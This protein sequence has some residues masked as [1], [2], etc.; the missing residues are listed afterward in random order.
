MVWLAIVL[1]V[2]AVSLTWFVLHGGAE[3]AVD[4]PI[5][6]WV[7]AHRVDALTPVVKVITHSGGTIAMW[8]AAI[9]ACAVLATRRQWPELTLVAVT[10]AGSALLIPLLKS[11][12]DR[13]RPPMADRLVVVTSHSYPSGHSLGS[14][15]VVGVIAAVV[16]AG[17]RRPGPKR[18]VAVAAA[19]FVA[20]V[21][22]SRV[23]LGVHWPTDVLAGWSIGLLWLTI[24]LTGYARYRRTLPPVQEDLP[25]S[26]AAAGRER[27]TG[28][29][30]G[31][32]VRRAAETGRRAH[33]HR[34]VRSD[35]GADTEP[36]SAGTQRSLPR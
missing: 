19:T 4:V 35:S 16:I 9:L 23:Y 22:L 7:V 6:D 2:S 30:R 24:M 31:A 29:Q 20:L 5:M 17:L 12:I 28:T 8:S 25:V 15:V 14:A 34:N 32:P 18:A 27:S 33:D 3:A 26:A 11:V 1:A 10:G 21:G 13:E 36:D